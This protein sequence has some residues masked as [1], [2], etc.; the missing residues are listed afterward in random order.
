MPALDAVAFLNQKSGV[1]GRSR[2]GLIQAVGRVMRTTPHKSEGYIILPVV[3][4]K[5]DPS[6]PI[7]ESN[8]QLLN[9]SYSNLVQIVND[10]TSHDEVFRRQLDQ[11]KLSKREKYLLD[12]IIIV[13]DRKNKT[14]KHDQDGH[15]QQSVPRSERDSKI[16][17]PTQLQLEII[18]A[19][20][21]GIFT[22]VAR[23]GNRV[24]S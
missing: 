9:S 5:K 21:D 18:Q 12:K 14:L 17:A 2:I 4:V 11:Y 3:V 1:R 8:Q 24:K 15:S 7:S 13:G 6:Q 22:C 19:I 10:L 20:K 23:A 16:P